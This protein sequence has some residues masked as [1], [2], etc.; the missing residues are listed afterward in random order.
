MPEHS[1]PEGDPGL[2]QWFTPFWGAEELVERALRGMGTVNLCEPAC[3]TGSFLAAFPTS[4]PAFGV[5]IDE[6]LIPAARANSGREVIQGDFLSLD[7]TGREVEV[8][9]GNPPFG[10][11]TVEAFIDRAYGL[12]PEGGKIGMILPAYAFQ[13]PRRVTRWMRL[14]SIDVSLIPRTLFPGLSKAL[15]WAEY[16]KVGERRFHGLML[17]PEQR[18][19]E[20]M[21]DPISD[22]LIGPGSWCGAVRTALGMLGGEASLSAIYDA[23]LPERRVSA[24]WRPKVRQSL[25]RYCRPV[26]RGR[27]AL[28]EREDRA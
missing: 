21:P 11:H 24:N 8:V 25:Q 13:T 28:N 12:I 6:R 3:G 5:E 19:I 1:V 7:L 16:L 17:F 18:D 2:D 20:L 23:M 27:W 22:A 9:L 14:F 4:C 26:E 15:V 10:M